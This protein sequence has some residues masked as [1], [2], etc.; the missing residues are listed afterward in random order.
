[1]HVT[2]EAV[3]KL[4]ALPYRDVKAGRVEIVGLPISCRPLKTLGRYGEKNLQ[5]LLTAVPSISFKFH[6]R[7]CDFYQ[8]FRFSVDKCV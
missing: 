3:G 5:D 2:G 4:R 6:D 8:A 1:M 7:Y